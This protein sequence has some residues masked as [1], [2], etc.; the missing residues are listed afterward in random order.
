MLAPL[1]LLVV[2]VVLGAALLVRHLL[3]PSA[4]SL[5]AS[6]ADQSTPG[7]VLLVP[8]YGGST[9]SLQVL[10]EAL[11][12]QG[13]D[14]TVVALP[15]DGTGDLRAQATALAVAATQALA[16]TGAGSVDV[17]GYSAGGVVARLWAA[18]DGGAGKARR[19][20]TLGSPHHGTG[21]ASLALNLAPGLCPVACQQLVPG[22][23]LL[24]GLNSGDET[25]SGPLWF[26]LWTTDD[27]VV[28]PPT[29]G[30]LVGAVDVAL[31]SVCPGRVVT[32]S[33]LPRDP[34]VIAL[35]VQ[36]LGVPAPSTPTSCPVSP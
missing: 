26:A 17:V 7:P 21:V 34:A 11:K 31:Q 4:P 28:T 22:G 35:V 30:S 13:R 14:A 27:Q 1:A 29:S 5:R 3:A 2:V 25:P 32:H 6:G 12:A 20:V 19:I 24:K 9:A 16:R 8:G 23:A 15:G 10:A 36:A 33:N 18:D